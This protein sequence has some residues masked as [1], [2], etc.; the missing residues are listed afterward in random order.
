MKSSFNPA[1]R[2]KKDVAYNSFVQEIKTVFENPKM[3]QLKEKALLDDMALKHDNMA[4][5]KAKVALKTYNNMVTLIEKTWNQ[6]EKLG[7]EPSGYKTMLENDMK[8]Y[9]AR[10]KEL[11]ADA[12]GLQN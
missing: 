7:D 10:K 4:L 8:R 5:K 3:Q 1:K 2:A 9:I 12:I 6:L 11:L